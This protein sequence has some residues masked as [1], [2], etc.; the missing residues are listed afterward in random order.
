MRKIRASALIAALGLSGGALASDCDAHEGTSKDKWLS[1]SSVKEKLGRLGYSVREIEAED[2]RYE[3]KATD[4]QGVKVEI[5]VNP[6]TGEPEKPS[7]E[8]KERS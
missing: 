4:K 6:L 2:G 7:E 1:E 8:S 5:Y 3:A